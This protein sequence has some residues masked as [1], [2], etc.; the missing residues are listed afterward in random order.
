MPPGVYI[1]GVSV[2]RTLLWVV[3]WAGLVMMLLPLIDR[4]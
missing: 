4:I 3:G 2:V 1:A